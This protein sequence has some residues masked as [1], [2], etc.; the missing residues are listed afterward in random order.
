MIVRAARPV[1][2]PPADARTVVVEASAG[3]G[4]TYFLEHR[5]ADLV[6]AGAELPQ[7]LL[8]TFTDKAVAELRTRIRDLL[9]RLARQTIDSAVGD[10]PA[11]DI[12]DAARARLRAAVRSF[13]HAPIF[14]IHGFCQRVLVEDAFAARR[15]F[16]QRQV[17]DDVAFDAAFDAVL[18]EQLALE[19]ADRAL[20]ATYLET[21][22]TVDQLRALLLG[23]ARRSQRIAAPPDLDALRALGARLTSTL[24]ASRD[25]LVG[26]RGQTAAAFQRRLAELEP[27]APMLCAQPLAAIAWLDGDRRGSLAFVTDKAAAHP[28]A[29]LVRELLEIVTLDQV[30]AASWLPRVL[31]R[32]ARD[33]AAAGLFDYDDMLALV[34]ETLAGPR[35]DQLAARLRARMPWAMID[36]FQDT[37][38]VQWRIFRAVWLEGDARGLT[39][40]GDPKQAIYGFRGADIATYLEARGELLARGATA[41]SLDVNRRSTAQLVDAVNTLLAPPLAAPL[42]DGEVRYDRPVTAAGDIVADDR[43]AIWLY[44]ATGD[45]RGTALAAHAGAI[46]VEIERLRTNPPRWRGRHGELPFAL[47]QVMVLTRRNKEAAEIAA[48][49]RA[50]GLPCS[51]IETD[52][53]FASR[54][55]A[56]LAD[57][58]AAL[59]APRD[60][61]ARMRALRTRFFAVSWAELMTVVEA[62]DHHPALALLFDWAALAAR[63]AY[64]PLFRRIVEDSM[65]V[66]RALVL[67][68]GERVLINTSHLLELLLDE[69]ARSRCDVGELARRMRRWTNDEVARTDERDVQRAETDGDAIRVLTVHKA[70][71]LEAPYVFFYGGLDA[72]GNRKLVHTVHGPNGREVVVAAR[73]SPLA[74]RLDRIEREEEQRL[75]YVMLTRAQVRLYL[76]L[77]G[78]A[79]KGGMQQL[80]RTQVSAFATA[81]RDGKLPGFAFERVAEALPARATDAST[82]ADFDPPQPPPVRALPQLPTAQLALAMLSYTRL[83]HGADGG[84]VTARSIERDEFDRDAATGEVGANELPA[85]AD[86]GLALHDIL[87]RVDLDGVRA[88]RDA[89]AW[90]ASPD[91][92]AIV[93]D[94]LRARGLDRSMANRAAHLAYTTLRT[95]LRLGD[96]EQ[97]P[98]LADA[99]LAREVEFAFPLPSVQ[100]GGLVRGFIDALA[101]WDDQLWIVDYKSDLLDAT[102]LARAATARANERYAIQA[103]L[104]ALAGD[105]LRGARSLAGM[106]FVFV[107]YGVAVPIRVDHERLAAWTRA[108]AEAVPS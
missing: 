79:V 38:P 61:S 101:A 75:T 49:L 96:G 102:D 81:A 90:F 5:V 87:E 23:C 14:T 73:K 43:A 80:V 25:D 35:G 78:D 51:V 50:R 88:A 100:R 41:I 58:L 47:G 4:K 107:R 46:G 45:A 68:G 83:A 33:K 39:I 105:R 8:V 67:G 6:L 40:V 56:E 42:L 55:A 65:L 63:R 22:Q 89:E 98:A 72:R 93:D 66:E 76:P 16:D 21:G 71:G 74:A 64:E 29:A 1:Q 95:P 7:I 10:E 97:L 28:I 27:L 106:L 60:R 36:E 70:K 85:G 52:D 92:A 12:D 13:D 2:L 17:A 104:Y 18:R 91:V 53:L 99:Q 44:D 30:V 24:A 57:L 103:Q 82:L 69:V 86:T 59:A 9:D 26:L 84:A 108:L 54:E 77:Y 11:W 20:L 48:A 31:E 94:A 62:P 3:T 15:L 37:D 19:P 34:A 32:V